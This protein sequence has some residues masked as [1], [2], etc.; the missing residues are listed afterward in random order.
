MSDDRADEWATH[1]VPMPDGRVTEVLTWGRG[2]A[3]TVVFHGGTPGGL[4]ERDAMAAVCGERGLRYVMAGRPGYGETSP[5]PGRVIA[6]VP[7]DIAVVLDHLGVETFISVGGSGGGPH[8][9]A[10]AALL[11]GRCA[12]AAAMVSPAPID[13]E[14]LDYYAGMGVENAEEWQIAE[15]GR[16][17]IEP[18]LTS[19]VAAWGEITLEAFEEQYAST[20]P[21]VDRRVLGEGFGDVF[22]ASLRKAVSTGVEGWVEDDLALVAPWGFDLGSITTPVAVW[23]GKQDAMVSYEHSVWLS[24]HIPGADLHVY[25]DHGHLSLPPALMPTILDDLIAKSAG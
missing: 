24:R 18:W 14:G 5:R 19:T 4:V 23:T 10:C 20:L 22:L 11:P 3:G 15:Q 9:L 7:E 17:R 12:A 25:G 2:E 21:E 16:E 8:V 6:D 1:L 13:A